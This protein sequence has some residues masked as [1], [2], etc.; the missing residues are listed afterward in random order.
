MWQHAFQWACENHGSWIAND[1]S[2]HEAKLQGNKKA[3]VA[4]AYH[5]E[6]VWKSK[7]SILP[8][9]N[10]WPY[11]VY[12]TLLTHSGSAFLWMWDSW[13]IWMRSPWKFHRLQAYTASIKTIYSQV[14]VLHW[15]PADQIE[16]WN[17]IQWKTLCK[18]TKLNETELDLKWPEHKLRY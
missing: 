1:L 10:R 15:F 8:Y 7:K 11:C 3:F 2:G 13:R 12:I 17:L 14:W 4:W 16:T 6:Q 5:A 18:H 9:E